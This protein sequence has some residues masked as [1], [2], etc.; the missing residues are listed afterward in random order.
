METMAPGKMVLEKINLEKMAPGKMAIQK[1]WRTEKLKI[2]APLFFCHSHEYHLNSKQHTI[3]ADE[4]EASHT[5]VYMEVHIVTSIAAEWIL[6]RHQ[7]CQEGSV[8]CRVDINHEE[9][10]NGCR[11]CTMC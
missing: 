5:H 3:Y 4:L 7:C 8:L 2:M 6:R 10:Q 9:R 11:P 1:K